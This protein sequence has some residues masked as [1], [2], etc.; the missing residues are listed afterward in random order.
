[1]SVFELQ[2]QRTLHRTAKPPAF[3]RMTCIVNL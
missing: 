2:T 3:A 1:M